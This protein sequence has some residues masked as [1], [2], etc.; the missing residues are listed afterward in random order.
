MSDRQNP[1]LRLSVKMTADTEA[2][3]FVTSAGALPGAAGN[4][5]GPTYTTAKNGERVAVTVL[6]TSSVISAAAFAAG[7]ALQVTAGGKVETQ[8]GTGVTV[9]RALEAATAA[10]ETVEAFI[11]PN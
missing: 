10:A 7:A 6:G 5:L 11:I 2:N 3:L 1:I 8:S 4:A 9:A